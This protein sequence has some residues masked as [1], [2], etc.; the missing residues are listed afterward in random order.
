M[1]GFV[2]GHLTDTSLEQSTAE[3]YR[4]P[5][6]ETDGYHL[7][8]FGLT[9][10]HHGSKD[11]RGC[12]TWRDRWRMG[13]LYG[14]IT[15]RD[16]MST[17]ALFTRLL[18][19]P[20]A[21]LAELDGS[22]LVAAIDSEAERVVLASDKLGTRQL[23]Y[24]DDDPFA[25]ATE[26]GALT[27]LLDDSQVNE[28][29][30]SDV[31]MSGHVWGDK[32]L[33][34]GVNYLQPGTVLEY[35]RTSGYERRR[36]WEPEFRHQRGD[37]YLSTLADAY[38]TAVEDA[39]ATT[40]ETVGTW[41]SGGLDDRLL[42]AA[43]GRHRRVTA[44]SPE[45]ASTASSN[46]LASA[47][48]EELGIDTKS[49][50]TAPDRFV[51]SIDAAV[52]LTSG[53]V[54]LGSLISPASVFDVSET[55][56]QFVEGGRQ[57]SALATELSRRVLT[58]SNSPEEAL[59]RADRRV[60][61]GVVRHLLNTSF[62]PMTSYRE[63]VQESSHS[64][65][66]G[67]TLDCYYRNHLSRCDFG[68]TP[69]LESQAGTRIPFS[70]GEF[71]TALAAMPL[72]HRV[73]TLPF[74]NGTVPAGT[75][76][77]KLELMRRL[78]ERLAAIPDERTKVAPSRPLWQQVVGTAIGSS[79]ETLRERLTGNAQSFDGQ[80]ILAEWY[81]EDDD[82]AAFVDSVL[83]S[84]CERPYFDAEAIRRLQWNH[85]TRDES[86][87]NALSGIVTVELWVQR[88]IDR[89]PKSAEERVA[90]VESAVNTS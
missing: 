55:P 27:A 77:P 79:I 59:Y 15:N 7:A 70:T 1:T 57:G 51:E 67:S 42:A 62:D 64:D 24:I 87:M 41:L 13:V 4:E 47:V 16:E 48:T 43:L 34:E 84:A 60:D 76:V 38:R 10:S 37:S 45:T 80:S 36:Y 63:A 61:V 52:Q 28:R 75:S 78:D 65:F 33:V 58:R 83:D 18:D 85:L 8:G 89:Q 39:A 26:V 69:L 20:D 29:A 25:F 66:Y 5:W 71:L 32:T 12:T 73:R 2:G 72:E 82:F 9:V 81:H 56:G 46:D 30:V 86:N 49:V 14:V 68:S 74:T 19:D 21:L 50:L 31:V 23:F 54:E 40:D 3:L 17:E 53:M 44:F 22:F 88:Y 11:P 6:Y 35:D 90:T